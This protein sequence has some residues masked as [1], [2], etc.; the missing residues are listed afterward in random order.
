MLKL[1]LYICAG[2]FV[3]MGTAHF[4]GIKLPVLFVYFDTPFYGY[5]DRIIAFTLVTYAS[6]F[7]AAA[8]HPQIRPFALVSIWSTVAGLAYVNVSPDLAEVLA[9]DQGTLLYWL[10]TGAFAGLAAVLTVLVLKEKGTADA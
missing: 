5:Q 7:V 4:F 10:Q 3:L 1:L 8:M 2:F 9:D 6:L